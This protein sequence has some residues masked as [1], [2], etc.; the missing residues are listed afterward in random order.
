MPVHIPAEI[1][2][3]SFVNGS[4]AGG[5]IGGS[6]MLESVFTDIPEKTLHVRDFDDSGAADGLERIVGESALADIAAHFAIE[7][8]GRETRVRHGSGFH[9]AN[10]GAERVQL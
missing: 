4:R 5:E 8:V 3:G 2:A 1:A 7:V 10:A 9:P 6:V